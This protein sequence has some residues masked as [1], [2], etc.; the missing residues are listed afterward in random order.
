MQTLFDD[1]PAG[2]RHSDAVAKTVLSESGLLLAKFDTG[3]FPQS[4]RSGEPAPGKCRRRLTASRS[5]NNILR[6][7]H[8]V[9]RHSHQ[10]AAASKRQAPKGSGTRNMPHVASATGELI[11]RKFVMSSG[12]PASGQGRI[13]NKV[14]TVSAG[15]DWRMVN[16]PS[17]SSSN[18]VPFTQNRPE[19]AGCPSA[20]LTG[21]PAGNFDA[22]SGLCQQ[23]REFI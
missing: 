12:A 22:T 3:F 4:S 13:L 20:W 15:N 17:P 8:P 16:A 10:M 21:V 18:G 19:S 23:P 7:G 9:F 6:R 14:L 2:G 11:L 5:D 1:H